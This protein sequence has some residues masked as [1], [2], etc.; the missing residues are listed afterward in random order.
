MTNL[1]KKAASLFGRWTGLNR[2]TE[3]DPFAQSMTDEAIDLAQ[4]TDS[5]EFPPLDAPARDWGDSINKPAECSDSEA[6]VASGPID[7]SFSA[8]PPAPD[9]PIAACGLAA[10][11]VISATTPDLNPVPPI[12]ATHT[13]L[14]VEETKAPVEMKPIPTP[15][16]SVTFTQLYEL[17]STEVNKRTEN[18]VTVYERLLTANR[19]ELDATRRNNRIA[20][21]IGGVMTAVAAFGAI[22]SAGEVASTRVEVGSLKQQV[23]TGQK[24]STERDQ[25]RTD[26]IKTRE[27]SAKIEIDA[28]KA[29]LDQALAVSTDRDRLRSDLEV[30]RKA[31]Q[32]VETELKVAR[33]AATQPISEA[34]PASGKVL[35]DRTD[36][37]AG[38]ERPDAWSTLLNG[39]DDH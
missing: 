17:I 28:L 11:P 30:A 35:A 13:E 23:A 24:A 39:R 26:L 32:D 25:L 7:A 36:K 10:D 19:E 2:R 12:A 37:V 22:W 29:R 16:P 20:W 14:P 31:R 15:K 4:S 5:S 3:I 33:G 1:F 18:A 38:A 9:Q 27:V 8:F 34:R 21:S 6:L